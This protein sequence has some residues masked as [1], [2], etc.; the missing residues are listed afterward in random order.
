MK[1]P[2]IVC[3]LLIAIQAHAGVDTSILSLSTEWTRIKYELPEKDRSQAFEILVE[4]TAALVRQHPGRAE[5]L[6][7]NAIALS[8]LAGTRKNLNA[9][10]LVKKAHTQLKKAEAIDPDALDGSVYGLLG[11]LY[12]R[13]PGRPLGFG[14]DDKALSYLQKALKRHPDSLQNH[15]FYAG[16]LL[17]KKDYTGAI[18]AYMKALETPVNPVYTK[19]DAAR[20]SEIRGALARL[21]AVYGSL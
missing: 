1:L 15:F 19:A 8:S 4:R 10:Q 7:W 5:P 2:A 16:Y 14:D 17:K 18:N 13:V 21:K 20:R 6:V 9:L 11:T 12:Y 3:T